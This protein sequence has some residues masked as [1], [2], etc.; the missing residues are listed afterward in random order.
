MSALVNVE[1]WGPQPGT[2]QRPWTRAE[3]ADLRDA[4]V[5]GIESDESATGARYCPC[6]SRS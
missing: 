4:F 5:D 1:P 3:E 6:A 2:V